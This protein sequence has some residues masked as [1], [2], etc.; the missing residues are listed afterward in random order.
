MRTP[1][2]VLA[3]LLSATLTACGSASAQTG[4]DPAV[5]D[6]DSGPV[7]GHVTDDSRTFEG[8]PFA[9]P[10]TGN[11]RW[12]DPEPVEPWADVRDATEPGTACTQPQDQPIAIKD[13]G[14]DCLYLNV[15]TPTDIREG[16]QLPVVVA[17][18]GGSFVYG[19]GASQKAQRMASEGRTIVV[20]PNYRLG[21]FGFFAHP[22]MGEPN[23]GLADQRSAL[24]WVQHNAEAF[25]GDPDNVT[26]MGQ[27]GGGLSVCSHLSSPESKGLID[28]AI[29]QSS[30]CLS[31]ESTIDKREA[32]QAGLELAASLNCEDLDCLRGKEA[33]EILKASDS[34]HAAFRPVHGTTDL[35]KSTSQALSSGEFEQVP[36]LTGSVG[37]EEAGPI[38]GEELATGEP[39]TAE[40][41]KQRVTE[42]FGERAPEILAEYPVSA[43]DT[44]SNALSTV[45]TDSSWSTPMH[46]LRTTLAAH[47]VPVH[48][49][50]VDEE[51]SPWFKI[52][53]PS[54]TVG[55][56][57]MADL[58]YLFDM[59]VFETRN[60]QQNKLAAV[61]VNLW[62]DFARNG[63]SPGWHEFNDNGYVQ[64]LS[65]KR[66]GRVD[67][68]AEHKVEFWS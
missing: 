49:Y 9:A 57:H 58:S 59:D 26:A 66:V 31:A 62:G 15:T 67:F 12:Q 4:D 10:P 36:I 40:D 38:A 3:V 1:V 7:K 63:G 18:H 34:G 60:A 5:V 13:N 11:A 22:E 43:Y 53:D 41:Y 56:D 21:A 39:L 50:E 47:D 61:M 29:L 2:T 14:E 68:V 20:T 17:I 46:E 6:T 37:D 51:D 55:T 28:K 64:G 30:T 42:E 23:L 52:G 65:T 48:A 45:K 32:E 54:F 19:D 44:P 16:E 24:E 8:I 27:S 33:G 35:P 25:G